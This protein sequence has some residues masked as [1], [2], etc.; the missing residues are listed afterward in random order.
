ML[1]QLRRG[2]GIAVIRV[3]G[4]AAWHSLETLSAGT[5]TK[6]P[7]PRHAIHRTLVDPQSGIILDHAMVI[8]FQAPKS[9]TGEDTIEYHLHGG[10]AVI[11]GVLTAL[12]RMEHLRMAQPGEFTRRAFENGKM[13]L[14]SA[15]AIADLIHAETEEQRHQA[16]LQMD[17][18]LA[19]LYE[20]WKDR[21]ARD[22]ALME[23]DLDFSDQDLPEDILLKLRPDLSDILREMNEH[24]NDNRRGE[25]L[26][27]GIRL[28][29]LGAPNAGKSSLVNCLTQREVAIVSS[30][31]GTTRDIIETHLDIGG[32]PVI[33]SDTAGLR[34]EQL[35]T[36]GHDLIESEG[37]KRALK[38]PEKPI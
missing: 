2:G 36:S 19:N 15:E 27:N 10:I 29:I 30:I 5:A 24:L 3:S 37:I 31:A 8:G 13:D 4:P 21:L 34:P 32:Y 18:A 1:Y 17:G 23:A 38:K 35:G 14:T 12:S 33:L 16:V 6:P 26:R 9:F 11:D 25:L 22:L 20:S 28:V 7:Q